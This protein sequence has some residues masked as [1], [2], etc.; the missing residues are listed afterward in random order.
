MFTTK[1]QSPPPTKLK[2]CNNCKHYNKNG[3]VCRLYQTTDLVMGQVQNTQ[4]VIAR[5]DDN[6]C[7][8]YA[9]D[10]EPID[11]EK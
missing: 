5:T 4:A 11:Y 8:L 2:F 1:V 9:K 10:Y 7:G 3:R 6:L